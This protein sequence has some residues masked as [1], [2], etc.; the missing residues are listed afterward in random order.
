MLTCAATSQPSHEGNA[1]GGSSYSDLGAL[2]DVGGTVEI[3]AADPGQSWGA[4]KRDAFRFVY[5]FVQER[6]L[7]MKSL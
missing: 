6:P 4:T 3:M 5:P 2:G 7:L 1:C